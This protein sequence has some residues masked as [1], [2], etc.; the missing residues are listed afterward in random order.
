MSMHLT[1]WDPFRELQE[2]QD[3]LSNIFGSTEGKGEVVESTMSADWVPAVDI[4]EDDK[5]YL[6]TADLPEVKKEE[7]QVNLENGVLTITGERKKESESK[8]EE[9]KYHRIERSYGRYE[10]SFRLPEAVDESKVD[11]R[12]KDG[13]LTI[14]LPKSGEAEE[15]RREIKIA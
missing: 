1:T 10:R 6:V 3:R 8:D 9:K 7:V 5:E 11:A 12:F 15:T 14:H 13:V 2:I 4:T